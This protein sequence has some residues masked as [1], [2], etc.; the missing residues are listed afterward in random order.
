VGKTQFVSAKVVGT[1]R[2]AY[3]VAANSCAESHKI[4]KKYKE[5]EIKNDFG[6][7]KILTC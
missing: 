3:H 1:Y 2:C 5:G 4:S 7:F 6:R